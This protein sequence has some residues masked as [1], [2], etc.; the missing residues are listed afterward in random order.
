[1]LNRVQLTGLY[2]QKSNLLGPDLGHSESK[3]IQKMGVSLCTD[4][5]DA[6]A[7]TIDKSSTPAL[8]L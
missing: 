7:V 3:V 1:M 8:F 4:A 6:S 2:V 5:N